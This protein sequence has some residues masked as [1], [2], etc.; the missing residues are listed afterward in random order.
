MKYIIAFVVFGLACSVLADSVARVEEKIWDN[1]QESETTNVLVTFKKANIKAANERIASLRLSTRAAILNTQHAILKDHADSVQADVTSM[2]NK[3]IS[4]GKRHELA[5][6][7]I[8]N[9]LIVRNVDL[10]TVEKLRSHPDVESLQAEWFIQ[11]EDVVEEETVVRSNNSI[12]LQWGVE[13]VNAPSV[14]NAGYNGRGI[15]VGIIDTGIRAT[16]VTL[17]YNYRGNQ[18][19]QL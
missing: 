15:T 19:G 11:L 12:L 17:R 13:N 10:E 3:A 2:L 1:L 4:N 18:P 6:L 8:T 16:H 5:Q 7:W 9:E 14:W